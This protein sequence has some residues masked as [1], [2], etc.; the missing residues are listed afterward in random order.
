MTG[1]IETDFS[2]PH[3]VS[4]RT[5][6]A[7]PPGSQLTYGPYVELYP[8]Q[9]QAKFRL[10]VNERLNTPVAFL[11]VVGNES[12]TLFASRLIN[13]SDFTKQGEWQTFTL[14]FVIED[15]PERRVE[16]RVRYEGGPALW[17][18]EVRYEFTK[19]QFAIT[20]EKFP[21]NIEW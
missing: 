21:S 13:G 10:K 14:P 3:R 12:K 6:D 19:E 9:Y 2:S 4:R 18:D 5:D 20:L 17:C 16:F 15:N 8:G 7:S 11:D 1:L